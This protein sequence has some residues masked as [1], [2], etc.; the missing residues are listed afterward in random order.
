[1]DRPIIAPAQIKGR[2]YDVIIVANRFANEIRR[3]CIELE[4]NLE[5]VIFLYNNYS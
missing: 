3:Q 1:M 4:I 2:E 5:K